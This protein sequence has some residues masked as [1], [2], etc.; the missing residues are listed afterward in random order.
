MKTAQFHRARRAVKAAALVLALAAAVAVVTSAAL[1]APASAPKLRV[2]STA[3]VGGSGSKLI[4]KGSFACTSQR[5]FALSVIAIQASTNASVHGSDPSPGSQPS[6][7]TP[8]RKSFKVV[9]DQQGEKK[10]RAIKSG[11]VRVCF[12]IRSFGHTWR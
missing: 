3:V 12:I 5:Y 8:P 6:T 10:P 11:S 2:S 9:A 7:C 4:V 1:A